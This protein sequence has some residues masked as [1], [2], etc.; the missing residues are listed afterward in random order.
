MEDERTSHLLC[1]DIHAAFG[2][3]KVQIPHRVFF[4]KLKQVQK[5]A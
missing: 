3:K 2:L 5:R 4:E 1:K